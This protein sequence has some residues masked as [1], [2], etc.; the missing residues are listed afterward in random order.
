MLLADEN[1]S[2]SIVQA[3][4]KAGFET[5]SVFEE[6]RGISDLEIIDIARRKKATV[7]TEDKDFG[8]LVFAHHLQDCNVILL[9][10]GSLA[11]KTAVTKRLLSLLTDSFPF[12]QIVFATIT[13]NKTRLTVI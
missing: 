1:L 9:R 11:E 4:R 6:L 13:S 3:L 8:E 5:F 12:E 2:I 7:V 10:Y